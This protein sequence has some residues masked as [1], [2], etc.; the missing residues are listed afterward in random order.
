MNKKQSADSDVIVD[1][2]QLEVAIHAVSSAVNR[3]RRSQP[4]QLVRLVGVPL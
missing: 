2:T 4:A 1:V 3:E